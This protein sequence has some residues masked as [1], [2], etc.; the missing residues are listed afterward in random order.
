MTENKK[1]ELSFKNNIEAL[2]KSEK[3]LRGYRKESS[4]RINDKTAVHILENIMKRTRYDSGT[5]FDV[6]CA[7]EEFFISASESLDKEKRVH[8]VNAKIV[9]LQLRIAKQ[10]PKNKVNN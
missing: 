5:L 8:N 9:D 7:L 2:A 3:Q 6:S 10:K 4:E 1:K